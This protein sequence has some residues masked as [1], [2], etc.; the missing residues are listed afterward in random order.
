MAYR[1][2]DRK[3]WEAEL[4]WLRWAI[5]GAPETLR[6]LGATPCGYIDMQARHCEH[7]GYVDLA[8]EMRAIKEQCNG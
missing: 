4:I 7:N 5:D 2:Y 1:Q 8:D 3:Y 6:E